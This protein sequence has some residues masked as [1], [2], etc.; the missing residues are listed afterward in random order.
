MILLLDV[1]DTLVYDP[2]RTEAPAFFGISFEEVLA[3]KDPH[4][5][6]RFETGEY[7]ERTFAELYFRDRRPVDVVGF[8]AALSSG[9]RLL[10]GIEDLLSELVAA[11]VT[12]H[13]LSN[14]SPWY[15][16]IEDRLHLS[17]FVP[18]TFVSCK[19]GVRKPDPEAYL[20]PARALGVS[21]GECLFVDDRPGNCAAAEA[22]GMPAHTFKDAQTLR[23]DLLARGLLAT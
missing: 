1:M 4:T 16:L 19:T 11:G 5:W 21:P 23:Q 22:V 15:Q 14:Y 10:A 3:L 9:Y 6:V 18:W 8:K 12:L 13:A 17:R 20:G 7:D 2:F